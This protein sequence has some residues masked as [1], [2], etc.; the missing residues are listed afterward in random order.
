MMHL[1]LTGDEL[2]AFTTIKQQLGDID[3]QITGKTEI[4]RMNIPEFILYLAK[5]HCAEHRT[6]LLVATAQ[7]ICNNLTQKA[8][9]QQQ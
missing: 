3:F 6:E 4:I 7:N 9:G 5:S 1:I 8:K 2:Q